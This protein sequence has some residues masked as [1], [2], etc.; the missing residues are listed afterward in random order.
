[1]RNGFAV[2]SQFAVVSLV[3]SFILHPSS[4]AADPPHK[5]VHLA[6]TFN[7]WNP[8]D[9]NYRLTHTSDG[10]Y[11]L[12]KFFRAGRYEMKFT[13][14]GDWAVHY[15][16]GDGGALSLGGANIVLEVPR[17][18]AYFIELDAPKRRWWLVPT[19]VDQAQ[20]VVQVRGV[21]EANMPITLDASQSVPRENASITGYQ[22]VQDPNDAIGV[23]FEQ[24]SAGAPRT[25]VFLPQVETYRFTVTVNDGQPGVA[26]AITLKALNSYQLLGDWTATDPTLAPTF[27]ERK[28]PFSFER[29][30]KSAQSGQRELKLVRDH[31]AKNIVTNV[32]INVTASDQ[33]WVIRYDEK[34]NRLTSAAESFVEFRYRPSDDPAFRSRNVTVR[35]VHLAGTFNGWSTASTP[36]T[37][38]ND[39]AYVAYLQLDEGLH[40]YKFV[41]NG[42]IW[43]Q[44]PKADPSLRVEDGQG[45]H[46]SAIFIGT[47][48]EE[49]GAPPA[50]EVNLTAVAHRADQ[51]RYFNP[52]SGDLVEIKLRALRGDAKSVSLHLLEERAWPWSLFMDEK[53]RVVPMRIGETRYGFDY[54]SANVFLDH[55]PKQLQ[56]FFSL[57]DGAT[58]RAFGDAKGKGGKRGV[59]ADLTPRFPTPD[60]AKHVVWYQI[61]VDRFRNG[62]PTNDPTNAVPWR[63]D[64]Y[65]CTAWERPVEGKNFSN[66]WYSRRFGGDLKGLIE[67]LP[68]FREL[69]V[70]ALYLCPVFEAN[71]Y[72]GYD[73]TDY[74]HV[75]SFYGVRGDNERIIAQ[76]TLDPATWQWTPTD[77]LFLD[78]VEQAHRHGLK[79]IVDGVFN[80]MGKSSF[81]LQD[82]LAKGTNSIYADW[83]DVNDWGPPV[84]Y[85]SWDGGGWMPNFRKDPGHGI[86][87]EGARKY[88]YDI[89]RR[90]MDPNGDGDP[91]EGI[92][93][94]R[95]DVAPDVPSAFWIEWRKHVKAINPQAYINGEHW[96]VATKHLRG[97]EWDAVM[98]YQFAIR[99]LRFF[100]DQRRK[101]TAT[102]FDRQLQELF[103]MY[104]LQVHMVM[105]NLYDSHDTDRLANMIVNADRD[106]DQCN[107]PQDGCPYDGSKPGPDAYRVLKLMTTFQMTFLGAPMIWYGNEAGM[108]GADDP[109]NRKAMLWE[110]LQPYD[111]RQ[112]AVMEDV[113]VHFQRLI[114]I[115]N[116]YPALRTGLFQ[117]I[118]M[119]DSNDLYG[120]TR[121]RGDEVVAVILNNSPRDQTIEFNS[122]F[123]DGARVVDILKAPVEFHDAPLAELGFPEFKKGAP[124]RAIR[125]A[126]SA[127]HHIA[128]EG[129]LRVNVSAKSA[130]ILV[131][132]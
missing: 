100:A 120:F 111:N 31:E 27:M 60:W 116:T 85:R 8:S 121:T 6:G 5:T 12:K 83:F 62:D 29:V 25:T 123:A 110:D 35:S 59:F 41:V 64:W 37:A 125:S 33:F 43:L 117:S 48:G 32:R 102:E 99:A 109:T 56:Y 95:L 49:F 65:K 47:R 17:H 108:F 101:I 26:E 81:A 40:Q 55:P 11:R 58:T 23:Y 34:A 87:S 119:H 106:Y 79:V 77:K 2:H 7:D 51:T 54:W 71:S 38:E 68:Y 113:L 18:G 57:S 14:E 39:G 24:G 15:G 10:S 67:K 52:V 124:R 16:A 86:A 84:K 76:E 36:M 88:L 91:S 72:H 73:T 46:N 80:H 78:F 42:S 22:F 74:R 61:M 97:D 28:G 93:G 94:W 75:S 50:N 130:A 9:P 21:I 69:G 45:G 20:P 115:R 92:D 126:S 103:A 122:P 96:G 70:T 13:T 1:V 114:A 112:D 132:P 82:V 63:F 30:L 90:W 127:P 66:D 98:N 44:D 118:L 104:P 89:T 3:S 4:F 128:R 19:H 129:K 131:R 53:E 105:Q 107:R